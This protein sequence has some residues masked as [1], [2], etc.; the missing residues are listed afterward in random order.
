M[1]NA[2]RACAAGP[3]L[4]DGTLD[5]GRLALIAD[6]A[7]AT[8]D[9]GCLE[10]VAACHAAADE[11][12]RTQK[13]YGRG[14]GVGA[15]KSVAVGRSPEEQAAGLLASHSVD[16]GPV[17]SHR[18]V[19]AMVAVRANQLC[20]PGSGIAPE[21]LR[22]LVD[23]LNDDD[24]PEVHALGSVGT[25]DLSA[26]ARVGVRLGG[27]VAIAT[28]SA[29]P[30]ISSSALTVAE[31]MLEA[32][33]ASMLLDAELAAYALVAKVMR[34]NTSPLEPAAA[35]A[36]CIEGA[37]ALAAKVAAVLGPRSWEPAQ[38]QDSYV[39]R[40]F[41]P[42]RANTQRSISRLAAQAAAIACCAQ[43]N[44]LFVGGA[45]ELGVKG[46]LAGAACSVI[47]HGAFYQ[48]AFAH[49]LDAACI[50][51]AQEGPLVLGRI[52][53]LNDPARSGLPGFLAPGGA[54]ASGTMIV[55]YVAAGAMGEIYAAAAPV[56]CGTASLSCGMEEDATFAT[57][58]AAKFARAND[59]LET[60]AACEL[61]CALR[62]ARMADWVDGLSG[63][64]GGIAS[65]LDGV[66]ESLEDRDLHDDLE[67]IRE[68]LP[69]VARVVREAGDE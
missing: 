62:A 51:L 19:R 16:A 14:T 38:V 20:H 2:R 7:A 27:R 11:L 67:F 32:E 23:M 69:E 58:A 21:V 64:L 41:V 59:A 9:E 42:A 60:V 56:S 10:R 28:D 24:L 31:V 47:H 44:P 45:Q 54:G 30:L 37:E 49:E 50:A 25:A 52:T 48:A 65:A 6:G 34:A 46:G 63:S 26:L 39:L 13:I 8:L 35:R 17:V 40:A 43:E 55:E 12:A 57:T 18:L 33:R 53:Q 4:I 1:E 15:N 29:L 68:R 61:L 36:T 3:V 22:A 66:R 5:A